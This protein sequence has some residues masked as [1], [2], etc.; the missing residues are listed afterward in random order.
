MHVVCN[1]D[2]DMDTIKP[3]SLPS[4]YRTTFLK[5]DVFYNNNLSLLRAYMIA[6]LQKFEISNNKG[7]N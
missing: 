2:E 3:L 7:P 1:R 4:K 5:I 6:I